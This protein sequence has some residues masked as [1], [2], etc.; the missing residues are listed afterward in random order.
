M[1]RSLVL[2]FLLERAGRKLLD[3]AG[4]EVPVEPHLGRGMGDRGSPEAATEASSSRS[5]KGPATIHGT[6][7]SHSSTTHGTGT[8]ENGQ[9]MGMRITAAI[10]MSRFRGT[11]TRTKSVK[12]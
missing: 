6:H 10:I 4:Q 5:I 1:D 12:R 8:G 11:P 2:P 7:L 9:I 3:D